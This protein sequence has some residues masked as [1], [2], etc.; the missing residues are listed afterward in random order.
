MLM[1]VALR[2][3]YKK[4]FNTYISVAVGN[5]IFL[6]PVEMEFLSQSQGRRLGVKGYKDLINILRVE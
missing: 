3:D 6:G 5:I 1:K 2:K 4:E